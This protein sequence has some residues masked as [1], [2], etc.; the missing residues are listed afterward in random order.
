MGKLFKY[1]KFGCLALRELKRAME[2]FITHIQ[3]LSNNLSIN[4]RQ[5]EQ[6]T[7]NKYKFS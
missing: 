6:K 2:T 7:N 3:D 4:H 1:E 5:R